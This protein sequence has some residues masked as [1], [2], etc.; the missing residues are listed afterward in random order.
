MRLPWLA[1][2]A[3]LM[4]FL[5]RGF[6]AFHSIGLSLCDN[7]RRNVFGRSC[8]QGNDVPLESGGSKERVMVA[9]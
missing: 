3:L 2:E 8:V 6:R 9:D 7:A 5:R 4:A 1:D